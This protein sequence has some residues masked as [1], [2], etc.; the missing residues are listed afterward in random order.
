MSPSITSFLLLFQQMFTFFHAF[1]S[2]SDKDFI[3]IMLNVI[4][5]NAFAPYL[6]NHPY[7]G[8][9]PVSLLPPMF[10]CPAVSVSVAGHIHN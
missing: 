3:V 8:A 5:L 7:L 2:T 10:L 6:S 9:L 1:R 4:K